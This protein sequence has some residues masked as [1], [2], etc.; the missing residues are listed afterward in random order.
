MTGQSQGL[1]SVKR[2]S[3]RILGRG[4]GTR[5]PVKIIAYRDRNYPDKLPGFVPCGGGNL[6]R[7]RRDTPADARIA[8]EEEKSG[9]RIPLY[10][11]TRTKLHRFEQSFSIAARDPAVRHRKRVTGG[12]TGYD[13][14]FGHAIRARNDRNLARSRF[15]A[16]NLWRWRVAGF[17]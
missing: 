6:Y 3:P 9:I 8:V 15:L 4:A 2:D 17:D 16:V 10:A 13:P 11:I 7:A 1:E 14:G 12:N 5:K